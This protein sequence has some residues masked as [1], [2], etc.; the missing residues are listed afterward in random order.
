[1]GS[2]QLIITDVANPTD[3]NDPGK[4]SF[5]WGNESW[6]SWTGTA[7]SVIPVGDWGAHWGFVHLLATVRENETDNEEIDILRTRAARSSVIIEWR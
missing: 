6:E 3:N 1:M 4:L 2:N 5:V 7:C